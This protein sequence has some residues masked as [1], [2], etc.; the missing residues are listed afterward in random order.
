YLAR[1]VLPH[2][3]DAWIAEIKDPVTGEKVRA[4]IGYD[5]FPRVARLSCSSGLTLVSAGSV[6]VCGQL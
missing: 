3:P 2:V 1:E 6:P 5:P 4:K